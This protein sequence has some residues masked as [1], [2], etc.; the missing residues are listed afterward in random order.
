MVP[1]ASVGRCV[2]G[3][4]LDASGMV[5]VGSSVA[6]V[7]V[8][9]CIEEMRVYSVRA[10][11]TRTLLLPKTAPGRTGPHPFA[12]NYSSSFFASAS[13]E[14]EA[15]TAGSAMTCSLGPS[16][17]HPSGISTWLLPLAMLR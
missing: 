5:V 2:A 11:A 16:G 14:A 9:A 1:V 13:S 17:S 8:G 15:S 4:E 3:S 10:T 7:S 6:I 12:N